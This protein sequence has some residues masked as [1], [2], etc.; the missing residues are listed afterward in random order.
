MAL[1]N[2]STRELTVKI[3]YYGP[4]L[5]GK[6]TNLKYLHD[7]IDEK[8]RGKML[9]L[10]TGGDRTLFFDILPLDMGKMKDLAVRIQLYTVPG[11]VFYE[12]TR[13]KVLMGVDGLVFVADSQRTIADANL[14][15]MNALVRSLLEKRRYLEDI[16]LVLQY[17]KRDLK[18]VLDLEEMDR[19]LNPGNAPFFEAV[20][21]EGVG[22][23]D[24]FKAISALTLRKVLSE[25]MADELAAEKAE[26]TQPEMAFA[27]AEALEPLLSADDSMSLLLN[28]PS[29]QEDSIFAEAAPPPEDKT[30]LSTERHAAE[31]GREGGAEDTGEQAI[32]SPE[33]AEPEPAEVTAVEVPG[34]ALKMVPGQPIEAV[35]EIGGRRYRLRISLDPE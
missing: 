31:E 4:G 6:T 9:S 10:S 5:C 30:L 32:L 19:E 15:S 16:P 28:N 13:K 1:L 26:K 23:E 7:N 18:E 3:V 12:E 14:E 29:Q 25:D 34:A 20:A 8:M 33:L 2:R 35:V 21:T 27:E 11:Q 17:N 22:V 24:T